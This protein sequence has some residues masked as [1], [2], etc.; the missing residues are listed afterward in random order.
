ML[1][2]CPGCCPE[3]FVANRFFVGLAIFFGQG[4]Y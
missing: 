4:L 1:L 2:L 3:A